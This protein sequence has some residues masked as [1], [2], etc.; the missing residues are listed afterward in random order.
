MEQCKVRGL[1]LSGGGAKGSFTQGVEIGLLVDEIV[2]QVMRV[3]ECSYEEAKDLIEPLLGNWL[4][5]PLPSYEKFNEQFIRKFGVKLAIPD[6]ESTYGVSVGGLQAANRSQFPLGQPYQVVANM[7]LIWFG[8][9]GNK[10]IYKNWWF[11]YLAGA[12]R[13]AAYNSKP[14]RELIARNVDDEKPAKSGRI[15]RLGCVNYHTKEY[16]EA[17]ETTPNFSKWVMATSAYEPFFEAVCIDKELWMDGGYRHVTP[18]KSA[19]K[20]GCE[21][22]DVVITGIPDSGEP[23]EDDIPPK[24]CPSRFSFK[25]NTI[26]IGFRCVDVMGAQIF[27]MDVKRALRKNERIAAGTEEG[28]QLN[29]RLFMPQKGLGSSLDFSKEKMIMRR[30][31]GIEVAKK[32]IGN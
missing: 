7:D 32:I 23:D 6:Y 27:Y 5:E 25:Y 8:L 17:T 1:V 16:F 14:L 4:T 11:W 30:Q 22:I 19:I 29:I 3:K 28:K 18:L 26:E 20:D 15:I 13:R 12:W 21:K 10:S 2:Q 31:H 9:K 24:K